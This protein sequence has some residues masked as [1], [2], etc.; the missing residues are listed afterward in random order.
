MQCSLQDYG[1]GRLNS[2]KICP[3]IATWWELD[4]V[5]PSIRYP[6]CTKHKAKG[7]EYIEISA[8][9]N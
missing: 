2:A 3:E 4:E 9:D 1:F 6:V 8:E 5:D 7:F